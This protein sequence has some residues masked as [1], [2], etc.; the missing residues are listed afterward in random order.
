M[1]LDRLAR[2]ESADYPVLSV[3]VNRDALNPAV[4]S[5]IGDLLKPLRELGDLDHDAQMSLRSDLETVMSMSDRI[6]ADIAPATAL[7]ACQGGGLLEYV[8]LPVPVWDVAIVSDRPYLRPLRSVRESELVAVAV[9]DRKHA[10]LYSWDGTGVRLL[11]LVE[12]LEEHK[13]NFGG[14][15]GYDE[16]RARSHAE[17]LERRHFRQ[18][19][20]RLFE[21]HRATPFGKVIVGGHEETITRFG[22]SLHPYLRDRLI[23]SFVIDPHTMTESDVAKRVD[24]LLETALR[25][26]QEELA[27]RVAESAEEGG[28]ATV[29]LANVL[30]AVNAGA[31]DHLVVAGR[32]AK[33]GV[34]CTTCGRLDRLGEACVGCGLLVSPTD[35]VVGAAM[36]QVLRMGGRVDQI[37][38]P[39][40]LDQHGVG[41]LLRFSMHG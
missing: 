32:F 21:H 33:D 17:T 20:D 28:R 9:V 8:S 11:E 35:D 14:F 18:V 38:V 24:G 26:E 36:E 1:H 12:E 40:L 7:F 31:V 4:R 13:G 27:V 10:R 3:Y 37:S 41:A 19:A 22:S 5:R 25:E 39:S 2:F 16:R 15:S 29:G 23:G 6:D 34:V 30:E